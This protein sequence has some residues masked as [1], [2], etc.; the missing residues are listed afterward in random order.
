[1]RGHSAQRRLTREGATSVMRAGCI[2]TV[3]SR[4]GSA[5]EHQVA[6]AGMAGENAIRKL[7]ARTKI[8]K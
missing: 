6:N 1:M 3:L 5:L 7:E 2:S 8:S 4:S